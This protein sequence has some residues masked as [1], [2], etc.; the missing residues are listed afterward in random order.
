MDEFTTVLDDSLIPVEPGSG[1]R[2]WLAKTGHIPLGYYKDENKTAATF[3]TD[4]RGIRWCLPGDYA[5]PE[6]DGTITL[7]GRGSVSINTGGEKVFPE[8]VESVLKGHPA[9]FDVLVVGVDDDSLGQRVV[10]VVNLRPGKAVGLEELQAF[11]RGTLAGFKVPR[12]LEVV[13]AIERTPAGKPDYRWAQA[14][15]NDRTNL[16]STSFRQQDPPT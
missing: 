12:R 6:A 4:E 5:I 14:L 9:I 16:L 13:E 7:L 8:E 10:A 15:V 1:S 11:A 3:P 2:G